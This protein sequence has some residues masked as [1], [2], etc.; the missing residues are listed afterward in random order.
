[1]LSLVVAVHFQH[2]LYP[3]LC[4]RESHTQHA[5]LNT[6]YSAWHRN[7]KKNVIFTVPCGPMGRYLRLAGMKRIDFL[8]VDVEGAELVVLNSMDWSIP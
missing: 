5:T 2:S 4:A 8:S 6:N 1:V 7:K 3:T